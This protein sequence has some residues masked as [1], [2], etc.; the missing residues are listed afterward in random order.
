M[1]TDTGPS[2]RGAVA[3]KGVKA[4]QAGLSS[5]DS[6]PP[7]MGRTMKA[8]EFKRWLQAQGATFVEGSR[9]TKV[10]LNGRQSVIPR[11]PS[12]EMK[13]GLRRQILSQLLVLRK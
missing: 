3:L 8:S 1:R 2:C 6:M 5:A 7:D 12:K 9:H 11:H 4:S 10:F 13:E